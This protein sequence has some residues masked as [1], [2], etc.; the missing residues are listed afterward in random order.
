MSIGFMLPNPD[1]AVIWRGPR[2]NGLIKQFL[3][4]VHWGECD[5]L[6]IDSPPGTS[7]EHISI[8]QVGVGVGC[9]CW[10]LSTAVLLLLLA[11]LLVCSVLCWRWSRRSRNGACLPWR[12]CRHSRQPVCVA[13]YNGGGLPAAPGVAAVPEGRSGGWRSGGDHA[14]GGVHHRCAQG[15]QFLQKGGH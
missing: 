9:V 4:D 2:K 15:N 3:K 7:D 14:P 1:D 13:H 8:A 11:A 12:S 10:L 6:I 5:Y